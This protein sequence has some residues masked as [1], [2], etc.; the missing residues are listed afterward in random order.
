MDGGGTPRFTCWRHH[1][2]R[3]A[4]ADQ[5]AGAAV[6]FLEAPK[7]RLGPGSALKA[8]AALDGLT[9]YC[10]V[11]TDRSGKPQLP[12]F[13]RLVSAGRA[14][15]VHP[16]GCDRRSYAGGQRQSRVLLAMI[17]TGRFQRAWA[18]G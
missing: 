15:R 16:S 12:T 10:L 1:P 3:R 7:M 9:S 11:F 4:C 5:A 13:R 6:Q 14:R 17:I 18:S 2:P 8:Y